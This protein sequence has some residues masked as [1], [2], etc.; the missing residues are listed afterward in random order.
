MVRTWT[1]G[2]LRG[3]TAVSA[4][5]DPRARRTLGVI[6][7]T[8]RVS[9]PSTPRFILYECI[10]LISLTLMCCPVRCLLLCRYRQSW[11]LVCLRYCR[12]P[13]RGYD[14]RHRKKAGA[15]VRLRLRRWQR[16]HRRQDVVKT[17]GGRARECSS[18]TLPRLTISY[19]RILNLLRVIFGFWID[20]LS[21]EIFLAVVQ[22]YRRS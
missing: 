19:I 1:N 8:S 5:L 7:E 16:G 21:C 17:V 15:P 18:W 10:V 20:R 9:F 3:C 22:D 4:R 12:W 11:L 14:G 6:P 13:E 2:V